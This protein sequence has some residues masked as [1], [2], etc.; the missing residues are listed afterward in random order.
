MLW[1][2]RGTRNWRLCNED[3]GGIIWVDQSE[4]VLDARA[5]LNLRPEIEVWNLVHGSIPN[6]LKAK[7]PA[8]QKFGAPTVHEP[9]LK[10]WVTWERTRLKRFAGT[11]DVVST[12]NGLLKGFFKHQGQ[13]QI[14][15]FKN[16]V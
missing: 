14:E 9:H 7:P 1:W 5:L 11:L 13:G 12:K 10:F 4:F 16:I 15:G 6:L 8:S 2:N 3:H